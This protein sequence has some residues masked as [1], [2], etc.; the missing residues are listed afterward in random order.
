M[1]CFSWTFADRIGREA[2][3]REHEPYK[4]LIPEKFG[5]GHL[6]DR[7][8]GYG[9]ITDWGTFDMYELIAFWNGDMKLRD[10][11]LVKD[12]LKWDGDY[13]FL[14]EKDQYTDHNRGIGIDIGC[15]DEQM[16]KLQYPLKLVPV[17]STLTYEYCHGYSYG[18]PNQGW[19]RLSWK[20][21]DEEFKNVQHPAIKARQRK[22]PN[23]LPAF[24]KKYA[25][26]ME[27]KG[28]ISEAWA[29]RD[30]LE[31]FREEYGK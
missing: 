6:I 20:H 21:Y 12:H 24:L 13:P 17:N 11:S 25:D 8:Q 3:L 7:Y 16:D 29:I 22:S 10:G 31:K 5:G 23:P 30:A 15:Y 27:Q 26:E 4:L 19:D 1:G 9:I 2:N 28:Y 14:K 18:D